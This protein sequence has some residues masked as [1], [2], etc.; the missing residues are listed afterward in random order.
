MVRC[1]LS[2]Q[3]ND[4]PN[5]HELLSKVCVHDQWF[6]AF[7]NN[8][9]QLLALPYTNPQDCIINKPFFVAGAMRNCSKSVELRTL[10]VHE[11]RCTIW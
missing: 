3:H 6:L 10:Q 2:I 4:F 5:F 7:E 8:S 1:S 11:H 9:Y